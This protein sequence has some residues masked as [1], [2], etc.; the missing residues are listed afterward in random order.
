M[1][2]ALGDKV[3]N[4][5]IF[6]YDRT[7]PV[8]CGLCFVYAIVRSCQQAICMSHPFYLFPVAELFAQSPLFQ[9]TFK[10]KAVGCI[11][12][13]AVMLFTCVLISYSGINIIDLLNIG[14]GVLSYF[15]AIHFPVAS[16]H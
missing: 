6:H 11:I 2:E 8:I 1:I 9:R 12:C 14:G 3:P 15:I 4:I 10:D 7:N 16:A 5:F 13:R